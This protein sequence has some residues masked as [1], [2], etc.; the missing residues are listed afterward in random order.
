MSQAAITVLPNAVVPQHRLRSGLLF[1][2]Q[3]AEKGHVQRSAA[4]TLVANDRLDL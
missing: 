3:R 2:P 1:G 4:T